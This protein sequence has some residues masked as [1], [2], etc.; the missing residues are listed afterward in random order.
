MSGGSAVDK[1]DRVSVTF[2]VLGPLTADVDGAP[3][4]LKGA[5]PRA[6]LARLL[7]AKG[8][9]VPIERL[10]DD[11]WEVAPEGA[12]A[13]IRTFVADLR[14]ALEPARP[15]RQPPTLLVT[16]PPGYALRPAPGTVDADRF[17]RLVQAGSR[18]ALDEALGLWRGPAYAEWAH[19]P[20]ARAEIDRL[21]ELRR[22]AVEQRAEALLAAG[23]AAEAAADLQ[24]HV[25]AHPL[26]EDAWHLLATALYRAGRQGEALAALRRARRSLVDELGV[27]L[28]PRL[29]R[30]E[31]DILHQTAPTPARVPD[32]T[33]IGRADEQRRLGRARGLALVS[34]EAGAGKSALVESVAGAVIV[35]VPE[36]D[37]IPVEWPWPAGRP[38]AVAWL[39]ARAPVTLVVD[40]LHRA[41]P[42]SLDLL[43]GI[44]A[45]L[46][47]LPGVLVVGTY[48][49]TEITPPLTAAL[50]RMA[51]A[52]PVRVHLGGL[53]EA[54]TGEL[55]H[56][57]APGADPAAVRRIHR[58][59][60]GNPFFVREV[61]RAGLAEAIPPGVRDV[62]RHRLAQV[63]PAAQTVLRQ[64]SV[65]GRDLDVAV[66][67][68]LAGD[69]A[70]VIDALDAALAAG[71]LEE[72]ERLRFTHIL[73]R[74]TL[75]D[76][77]SAVRRTHWHRAAAEAIERVHPDDVT[78][79]AHHYERAG[80]QE[81]GR[82][83]AA[84]AALAERRANPHE[85]ARLWR[86]A[87]TSHEN[88]KSQ[89]K[90][91]LVGL[92]RS[93]AVIGHLDEA[94]RRRAEA[95]A[96]A[97]DAEETARVIAAFDVPAVWPRNDDEAL[98]RRIVE[99]AERVLAGAAPAQRS[100]LLSA[101]ALE[102][103][104]TTSDRGDRAA[105]EAEAIARE[106]GDPALLAFALNARFMHTF[107]RCGLAPQRLALGTEL[108]ALA[109]AHRLVTFEVLGHLIV[110]QAQ[111]ALGDPAAAT[112]AANAADRLAERHDLPLVGLFTQLYTALRTRS[113]SA[114]RAAL[115]R[116]EHSAMP[117]MADGL[118]AFALFAL[119]GRV[120][121]GADFGPYEP[122]VRP[123]VL[124]DPQEARAA[125]RA[126]PK[127]PRDLLL[128]ARLV[129]AARAAR[130]LREE[131]MLSGVLAQLRPAR[132]ELAAG[133][134]VLSFGPIA[135]HYGRS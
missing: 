106:L 36:S 121:P 54:A 42:D 38:A 22:R 122:W 111:C 102:L 37:G 46:D 94:R 114:Y 3:A 23:R 89:E 113:E 43:A 91:A 53:S 116:L 31:S 12:V 10:V 34:G 59:T 95:I 92:G 16:V 57:I 44:V 6:V 4:A 1:L 2:G 118:R 8:H 108:V 115:T 26:R 119:D 100:R 120:E 60:G 7:V 29:R 130:L 61:A 19:E 125:L 124:A 67:S 104:G 41:D 63:P 98:S 72:H 25:T 109:A 97:T 30:L 14:R 11:L 132:D 73:V 65:L 9:V 27:D 64:A 56:T 128:E 112:A 55:V 77:L 28:S 93:L 105:R 68:A 15:P 110:L 17:E 117:G 21:D 58:R 88:N 129:L 83:A 81:A 47:R 101:I 69:E 24:A 71:F 39:A 75:Y 135:V 33:V 35:R 99:A 18:D 5:R 96:S 70:T 13:A 51:K 133:S 126:L 107:H 85:A 82:Y 20:W 90:D 86:V 50:A 131:E 45:E 62:I 134:G 74:D 48:R 66:L 84:A 32:K 103:R 78:A 79:L 49:T 40:D 127:P 76:D 52:E 80:S 87:L 123:L